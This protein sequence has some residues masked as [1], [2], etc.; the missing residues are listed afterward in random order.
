MT[1]IDIIAVFN[2]VTHAPLSYDW[3]YGRVDYNVVAFEH[4]QNFDRIIDK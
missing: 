3:F 2:R 1:K 4:L